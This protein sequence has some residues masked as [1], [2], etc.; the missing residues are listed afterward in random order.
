MLSTHIEGPKTGGI[1]NFDRYPSEKLI[2]LCFNVLADLN[3]TMAMS[4]NKLQF[5]PNKPI[6]S[7]NKRCVPCPLCIIK[8]LSQTFFS[9]YRF[10]YGSLTS[11]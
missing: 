6:F 10:D 3:T 5:L 1:K 4:L 2:N 11:L 7:Q 8:K 9:T